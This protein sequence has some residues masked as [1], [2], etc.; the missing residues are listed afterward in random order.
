MDLK[1]LIESGKIKT[2]GEFI[3][4]RRKELNL[5][6]KDIA[7]T[8]KAS[9]SNVSRW[10]T[11]GIDKLTNKHIR[12]L[13]NILQCSPMIFLLD[14]ND[15]VDL[16][17]I[18]EYTSL[19]SESAYLVKTYNSLDGRGK[20]ALVNCLEHEKEQKMGRATNIKNNLE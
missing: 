14:F 10:Q 6:N 12:P 13:A 9:T 3:Y 1:N 5:T 4:C 19:D 11:G 15:E 8:I 7:K 17:V 16:E 2:L 18:N 20:K